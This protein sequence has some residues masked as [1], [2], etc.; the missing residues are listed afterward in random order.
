M[1]V[2]GSSFES[3]ESLM[4]TNKSCTSTERGSGIDHLFPQAAGDMER[5]VGALKL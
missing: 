3:A 2:N 5:G 4:T 1:K